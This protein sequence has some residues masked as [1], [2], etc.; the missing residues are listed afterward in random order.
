MSTATG[1][2][3][4][5]ED[6]ATGI[7]LNGAWAQIQDISYQPA[8]YININVA[9]YKNYEEFGSGKVPVFFKSEKV[10]SSDAAFVTYFTLTVLNEVNKNIVGQSIAY[11][12]S[13]F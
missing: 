10:F 9:I 12:E 4:D 1:F 8:S 5:Y 7:T 2:T 11:L 3:L 6:S 13:I